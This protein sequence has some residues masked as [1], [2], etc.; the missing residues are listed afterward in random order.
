MDGFVHS[1]PVQAEDNHRMSD[2]QL[3]MENPK[4]F[5]G[6]AVCQEMFAYPQERLRL[7][8][9]PMK[10]NPSLGHSQVCFAEEKEGHHRRQH[11][12][13]SETFARFVVHTVAV[14]TKRRCHMN[15]SDPDSAHPVLERSR[16]ETVE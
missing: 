7:L 5:A 6:R 9:R 14:W 3:N 13:H 8:R 15:I 11:L 16:T 10:T 2:F 12:Q 4:K 1:C